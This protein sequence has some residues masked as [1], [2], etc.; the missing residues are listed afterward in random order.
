M[1]TK[2][3]SVWDGVKIGFGIFIVLPTIVIALF[4]LFICVPT[5]A[6]VKKQRAKEKQSIEQREVQ[7]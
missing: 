6:A 4:V 7:P 3:I 2:Q 5:C 1:N